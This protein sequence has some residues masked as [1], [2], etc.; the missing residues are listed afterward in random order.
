[1][2]IFI[3][4]DL[5][6][7]FYLS[8]LYVLRLDIFLFPVSAVF[9][10]AGISVAILP[11]PASSPAPQIPVGPSSSLRPQCLAL[12]LFCACSFL[13]RCPPFPSRSVTCPASATFT[14]PL[15]LPGPSS[16]CTY[17]A[18]SVAACAYSQEQADMLNSS[19]T[20]V[21]HR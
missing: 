1:M 7:F 19:L 21:V 3:A 14:S 12:P 16:L 6:L 20:T 18:Q 8:P 9:C 15:Y 17:R 10:S 4:S 13:L 2:A 5:L 11:S